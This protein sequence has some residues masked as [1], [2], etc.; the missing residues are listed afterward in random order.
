VLLK[1]SKKINAGEVASILVNGDKLE[2]TLTDD[3]KLLSQK[4]AETGITQTLNNYGVTPEALSSISLKIKD[5]SGFV[6]WLRI[7]I[8][9]L[10]PLLIIGALFFFLMKQAKGGVNQAF[11][12]GRANINLF[13]NLK[14]KVSFKDVAGLKE[15]K[16]ELEEVVDFL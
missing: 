4:E 13:N 2:V 9:T 3:A 12:F 8:P 5:E 16:K 15:A 7:I 6:F 10:L 11:S 14:D 1:L